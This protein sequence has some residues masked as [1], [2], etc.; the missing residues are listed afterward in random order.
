MHD[1][2]GNIFIF[3]TMSNNVDSR[4][5]ILRAC[6]NDQSSKGYVDSNR[7]EF[8]T[9]T[10]S[11]KT[12]INPS[13]KPCFKKTTIESLS[14]QQTMAVCNSSPGLLRF[15]GFLNKQ[16]HLRL[17]SQSSLIIYRNLVNLRIQLN[18]S[19]QFAGENIPSNCNQ[20]IQSHLNTV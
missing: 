12:L 1:S 11:R 3:P 20:R 7:N 14:T 17:V 9:D 19:I 6:Y 5:V 4:K 13:S 10:R 18:L 8:S 2:V 15:I 16:L